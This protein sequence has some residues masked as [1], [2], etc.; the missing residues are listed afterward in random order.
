M[1]GRGHSSAPHYRHRRL[2]LEP[3]TA[4]ATAILISSTS[5]D[6]YP[7]PLPPSLSP[8]NRDVPCFEGLDDA[9]LTV[10]A[11]LVQ[12]MQFE[13]DGVIVHQGAAGGERGL[14]R[15]SM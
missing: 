11:N 4:V 5:A 13:K 12:V 7:T 1:S 9:A 15:G 2:R 14:A 3:S 8:S 10:A 6:P